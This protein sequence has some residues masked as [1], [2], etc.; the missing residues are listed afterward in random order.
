MRHSDLFE[1]IRIAYDRIREFIVKTPL[2]KYGRNNHSIYLKLENSQ[3]TGSFKLR[4]AL[5]KILSLSNEDR[6]EGVIAA[7]TGNHAL[8]TAYAL[9]L[10]KSKGT[11]Y[12]PK[13]VVEAK[14]EKLRKY[15]VNLI[16]YGND[17]AETEVEARRI[18]QEKNKPFISPYNDYQIIAGQGTIGYEIYDD[19][20]SVENVF[21]TVGGGGLISGI[22]S[23]LKYINP[24]INIY[25]CQPENSAV[26]YYSIKKGKIIDMESKPTLSDGSAGG[27]ES[28]SITFELVKNYV[29]DFILV[30]EDEIK[31]ALRE[32]YV[33]SKLIVEGAAAVAL[34][35]YYKKSKTVSGDSVIVICGGNIDIELF[36]SIVG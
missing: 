18:S 13:E 1:E 22:A 4:G 36:N 7:S 26:M 20:K 23:Y 10:I 8:A 34:A 25:A 11:I 27:I 19:L 12:L 14:L 17:S 35:A 28:N 29:D 30:T 32:L 21:V 24:N 15:D 2:E 6:F 9:K 5:N 3:Y 31:E 16:H 33:N